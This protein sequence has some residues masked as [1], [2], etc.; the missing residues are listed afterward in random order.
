MVEGLVEAP[1]TAYELASKKGEIEGFPEIMRKSRIIKL[2]LSTKS[3]QPA[4]EH[5]EQEC[6]ALFWNI[7]KMVAW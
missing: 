4:H 5:D 6:A 2:L 3:Y 1:Q 7:T